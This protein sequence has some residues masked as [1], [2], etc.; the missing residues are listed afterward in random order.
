M[1]KE[2][3]QVVCQRCREMLFV[4]GLIRKGDR[5]CVQEQSLEPQF[6]R[7]AICVLVTVSLVDH[8]RMAHR[9]RVYPNLVSAT[10]QWLTLQQAVGT[11]RS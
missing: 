3:I 10:G 5:L 11:V 2:V 6:P 4:A 8:E 7:L 1:G 9:L